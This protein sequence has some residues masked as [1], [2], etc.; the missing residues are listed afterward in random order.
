MEIDLK[1][2]TIKQAHKNLMERKY[3]VVQLTQ[4]YLDVIK[5]KN[6]DKDK[7]KNKTTLSQT[8]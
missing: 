6:K 8:L 5:E 1:N 3:S 7:E 4:A 2:L